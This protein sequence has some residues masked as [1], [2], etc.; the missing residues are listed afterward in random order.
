[1]ICIYITI[2]SRIQLIL[3]NLKLT[4]PLQSQNGTNSRIEKQPDR[5]DGDSG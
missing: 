3:N 5:G 2:F 4:T 1:M